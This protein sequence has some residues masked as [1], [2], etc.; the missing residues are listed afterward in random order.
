M[1]IPFHLHTLPTD[2]YQITDECMVKCDPWC[3]S[4]SEK[5]ARH[6]FALCVLLS[7]N[8]HMCVCACVRAC[9]CV[10]ACVRTG[11]SPEVIRPPGKCYFFLWGMATVGQREGVQ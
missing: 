10:C 11:R 9:V 7:Y 5:H 6:Y 4:D 3:H 2:D 8:K 1:A